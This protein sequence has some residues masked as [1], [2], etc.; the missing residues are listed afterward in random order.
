MPEKRVDLPVFPQEDLDLYPSK[1]KWV[2]TPPDDAIDVCLDEIFKVM[3][4]SE[5][6][7]L[8]F[9][10]VTFLSFSHRFGAS[11]VQALNSKNINVIHTFSEDSR[12]SRRLKMGFYMGDSRVKATTLHSF[13]GWES[14]I[15]VIYIGGSF[16]PE[17]LT[18][19]YTGLTRLKRCDNGG[20]SYLTIISSVNELIEYGKSWPD[21]S[22]LDSNL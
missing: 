9:S 16:T 8:A 10:D 14:R 4:D 20:L 2:H 18:L 1:L 11:V 19:I 3:K 12:E 22:C 21:F 5:G 7:P 6:E 17:S 15:L 13:K